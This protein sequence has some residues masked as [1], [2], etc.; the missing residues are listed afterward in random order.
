MPGAQPSRRGGDQCE[1]GERG[2]TPDQSFATRENTRLMKRVL[3]TLSLRDRDILVRFY[4]QEQ[5][6]REM[7][8]TETQFRLL[9]SRARARFG[10]LGRKARRQC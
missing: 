8:L 1:C 2:R 9:K 6:C 7:D 3:S 4:L 5:I 10:E